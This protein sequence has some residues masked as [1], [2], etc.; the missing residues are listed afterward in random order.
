MVK[1]CVDKYRVL[2][3][4][5]AEATNWRSR[6]AWYNTPQFAAQTEIVWQIDEAL[7]REGLDP[8]TRAYYDELD[9]RLREKGVTP[10]TGAAIA[11]QVASVTQPAPQQEPEYQWVSGSGFV[12]SADGHIVTNYHVLEGC[13]AP[14]VVLAPGGARF[15]GEA[16]AGDPTND[17]ALVRSGFRSAVVATIRAPLLRTGEPVTVAGFP[18]AGY[19]A[20][21]LIVTNGIVNA[22]GG[23]GDDTRFVQISAPVQ[24]GNSGGPLFDDRGSVAGI[25]TAGVPDLELAKQT[26]AVPQNIN[27]AIKA[28]LIRDFLEKNR[29]P[30]RVGQNTPTLTTVQIADRAR[31][32][33]VQL[34]CRVPAQPAQDPQASQR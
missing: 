24:N 32:F 13:V 19:L 22:L 23:I 29:V 11:P 15:E 17:M 28:S 25:V 8:F 4:P 16:I 31:E 14:L 2:V 7:R 27:F 1:A 9:K 6:N 5:N 3:R 12:V 10:G 21:D 30:F 18:L 20:S 26:G 33:T 34:T